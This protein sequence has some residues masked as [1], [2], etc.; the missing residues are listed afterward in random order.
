M[1]KF[2]SICIFTLLTTLLSAQV[3]KTINVPTAGTLSTLLTADEKTTITNLTVTGDIDATDVKCMRNEITKLAVLD[4][5]SVNIKAYSGT[6]GTYTS[7]SYPAN[8]MPEYS[9]YNSYNSAGK[10]SLIT[11]LLPTSITSIG[12]HA[13]YSCES[14]KSVIIPSL[15][16][17]LGYGSF[18]FCRG[19][20]NVTIPNSVNS[21]GDAA[22]NY[23]D[24]LTDL[25]IPN[26]VTTIG[27]YAFAYC[28]RLT[29]IYSMNTTPPILGSS[30][31]ANVTNV[32]AVYVP[33]S[34]I[35]AYKAAS[36][37]SDTFFSVILANDVFGIKVNIG[38][39]GSV[40]ENNVI[41]TDGSLI[42]V[43]PTTTKTF[44]LIPNAGYEISS[45][46]YNGLDVKSQIVNNQY[47]TPAVNA[48]ATLSVTFQKIQY[49]VSLK[50]ASSG[51][52]NLI[53]DYGATPSFDF[54]PATGW[55]VNTVL[56]N[57]VDVTSSLVNG[58]YTLPSITANALLN[59]SFTSTANGAP[60]VINNRV[61][62]YGTNTE[63]IVE[64]TSEGE[65]VTLYTING[66]QIQTVM[67]KGERLNLQV[68]RDA[69]YLV[70]TGEK[71]FKVIL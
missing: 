59:V 29:T 1:K 52:I 19:I 58:I 40:K 27:S 20:T 7:T 12:S 34:A 33:S 53:C 4:I 32:T 63:I 64:G 42:S 3:S 47:T 39:G 56:Y 23:C 57:S 45:L 50:D 44:T 65:T 35:S 36:G 21:I 61:K 16:N 26:S 2:L 41:I 46:I 62:V 51:T 10:T 13:F 69:V 11:I 18:A 54:T 70:K 14:I 68:D 67:S 37:W 9:F 6:A 71:T 49:R 24:K 60:E 25:T 43:S 55:R 48:S 66:K 15:V 30:C 28:N 8:E 38:V 22:F 5:S 31:F 17:K